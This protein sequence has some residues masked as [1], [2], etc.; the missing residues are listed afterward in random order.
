MKNRRLLFFICLY[1]TVFTQEIACAQ[2]SWSLKECIEY[3]LKSNINIDQ[4]IITAR[5]AEVSYR[6]S[7]GSFF[8][9]VNASAGL[10]YNFGRSLDQ[11]TYQFVNSTFQS[12]NGSLNAS[13]PL[14]EG[15]ELQN[16][17]RKNRLDAEAGK[18]DVVK[19][20]NDI[21]LGVAT[22]FLQVLY[23][24]EQLQA[25][26]DRMEQVTQERKRTKLLVDND[27]L[28]EGSLLD[29]DALLSTEELNKV[30]VENLI[31]TSKLNL[32]Q[33]MQLDFVTDIELAF[34]AVELPSQ[35]SLS[36]TADAIYK[37]AEQTLPEIK[38]ADIRV[39]SA[40]KS[41]A[42]ARGGRF[43][44]LSVFGSLSSNFSN[45]AR[46]LN[47]TPV[48]NGF[49]PTGAVTSTG[50]TVLQPQYIYNYR[51][52]SFTDQ[53]NDNF[54]KAVGFSLNIPLFNGW[55]VKSNVSR[56]KLNFES[57]RLNAKLTRNNTFKSVQQA[58]ADA[59][60]AFNKFNAATKS[61]DALQRSFTYTEKK[62]NAGLLNSLDYITSRNNLTKAQS[63][64][65]Q[66]KYDFILKVKV[67][68]FYLG[69]PLSF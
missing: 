38:S 47:G 35:E 42:I 54:A 9:S 4:S 34:P 49:I 31:R 39:F 43:P 3:A 20:Q 44:R 37:Q 29:A 66:A 27:L 40:E 5:L 51:D 15:L 62:Y 64:L 48:F 50:E 61:A 63:D 58:H 17:L 67:L 59:L 21:A 57:A 6:Q 53:V 16:T 14:F 52:V 45:Q 1:F 46:E 2:K 18:Q 65:L 10:N 25:A 11:T 30:T 19:T 68:D 7:M 13:M 24:Q 8:P 33:L 22:A 36:L 28:A 32:I 12:G 69:K 23:S 60:A 26:N 56:A 41:I 55:S